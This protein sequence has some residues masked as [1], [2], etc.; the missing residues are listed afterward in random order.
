GN[1]PVF[2][3]CTLQSTIP[4]SESI[5]EVF[6]PKNPPTLVARSVRKI[7]RRIIRR[8]GR[9]SRLSKEALG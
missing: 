4:V 2:I 1:R 6:V 9:V 5:S 7:G 3:C 8:W